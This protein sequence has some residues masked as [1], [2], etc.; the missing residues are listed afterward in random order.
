MKKFSEEE[1]ESAKAELAKVQKEW[2]TRPGVTAIDIGY[3]MV[4]GLMRDELAIRV[5]VRRKRSRE[6]LSE[7]EIFPAQLGDFAVDVIE[8]NYGLQST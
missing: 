5:H 2:I 1:I 8:A 3:R 7:N 4:D 6:E